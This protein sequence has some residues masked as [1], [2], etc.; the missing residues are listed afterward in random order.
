M[1]DSIFNEC[2]KAG[3]AAA[4]EAKKNLAMYVAK[5]SN[6]YVSEPFP[7]CGFA[8]VNVSPGTCKFARW[9][10]KEK[11]THKDYYGGE[12]I[13]IHAYDQSYDLKMAYARGFAKKLEELNQTHNLGIKNCYPGGRLD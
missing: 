13:W 5:G 8:W 9:L 1:F 11:G 2:A 12:N 3:R 6:G 4:E 10:R 7:I